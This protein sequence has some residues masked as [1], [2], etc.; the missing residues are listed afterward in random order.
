MKAYF[1]SCAVD[2][3][4]DGPHAEALKARIADGQIEAWVAG[5][6]VSE[7]AR[8]PLTQRDRRLRLMSVIGRVLKPVPTN[9]PIVGGRPVDPAAPIGK[10]KKLWTIVATPEGQAMFAALKGIGISKLDAVHLVE[11]ALANADVF[12]TNDREDLHRKRE[13][14]KKITNVEVVSP[15]ELL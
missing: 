9:I 15:E 13:S 14:I 8:T 4:V 6:I 11:A 12:V 2:S 10:R 1:D 5:D 3:V 7:L